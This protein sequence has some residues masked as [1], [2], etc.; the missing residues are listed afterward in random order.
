MELGVVG[1]E[2]GVRVVDVGVVVG[3]GCMLAIVSG[4]PLMNDW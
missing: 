3:L 1:V 2:V 4:S